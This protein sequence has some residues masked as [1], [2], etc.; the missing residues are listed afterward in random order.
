MINFFKK[1]HN[2]V[3]LDIGASSLKVVELEK[4]GVSV[5]LLNCGIMPIPKQAIVE[6]TIMDGNAL[7]KCIRELFTSLKIK[8]KQVA[9]SLSGNSVIIKKIKMAL[10]DEDALKDAIKW[11]AEQY[12]PFDINDVIIDYHVL[13]RDEENEKMDLVLVAAKTEMIHDYSSLCTEAGLTPQIVDVDSFAIENCVNFNYQLISDEVYVLINVGS[14]MTNINIL[15]GNTSVFTRDINIG[16]DYFTDEIQK[17]LNIPFDQAE[18]IKLGQVFKDKD[19]QRKAILPHDVQDC[20]RSS[21][22]TLA[23]ELH[24]SI[25]YF[26]TTFPDKEV[27]KIYLS[28]GCAKI[29]GIVDVLSLEIDRPVEVVNPFSKISFSDG[30]FDSQS[31]SSLSPVFSVAMGLS[32]RGLDR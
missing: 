19:A 17:I 32:L 5:R 23:M 12:I 25:D 31:I 24:K 3:G 20:I 11:E 10:M 8:N 7:I 13:S 30:D 22:E 4:D 9:I 1:N 27:S 28:G 18:A 14:S 16:G 21:S 6:S 29:S 26:T 2:V 15:S